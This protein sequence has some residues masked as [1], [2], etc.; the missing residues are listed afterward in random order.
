[1]SKQN[2]KNNILSQDIFV[3][4]LIFLLGTKITLIGSLIHQAYLALFKPAGGHKTEYTIEFTLLAL[5]VGAG[6]LL[7]VRLLSSKNNEKDNTIIITGIVIGL[8]AALLQIAEFTFLKDKFPIENFFRTLFFIIILVFLVIFPLINIQSSKPAHEYTLVTLSRMVISLLIGF[9]AGLVASLLITLGF[10]KFTPTPTTSSLS[11]ITNSFVFNPLAYVTLSTVW[12]TMAFL[13]RK[14][15]YPQALKEFLPKKQ[16]VYKALNWTACVIA[17]FL[18]GAVITKMGNKCE[19]NFETELGI[20]Y[21]LLAGI[22]MS[23]FWVFKAPIEKIRLY[24]IAVVFCII[25]LGYFLSFG[26]TGPDNI[27]ILQSVTYGLL[28]IIVYYLQGLSHQ[29][30]IGILT[31]RIN[32]F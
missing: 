30:I 20:K 10:S 11:A 27:G 25:G 2:S 19:F 24:K 26:Q 1:M 32:S 12:G 7:I 21:A 28:G 15:N 14:L 16:F 13:D 18:Y 5:A 6:G 29:I 23:V 4:A 22:T 3:A 9:G 31:K 17:A 8:L